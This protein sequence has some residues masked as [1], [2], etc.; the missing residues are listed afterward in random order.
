[1]I[2]YTQDFSHRNS[3][4]RLNIKK[5]SLKKNFFYLTR[6]I[7]NL[8]HILVSKKLSQKKIVDKQTGFTYKVTL[9]YLQK[10]NIRY[11]TS[12]LSIYQCIVLLA[13]FQLELNY[14]F[15]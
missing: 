13:S 1:M 12:D 5:K 2:Y 6:Y 8:N 14:V 15:L 4:K 9:T 7:A 11:L 3:N 10:H